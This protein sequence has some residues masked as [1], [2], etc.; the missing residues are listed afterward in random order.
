LSDLC[1]YEKV[2]QLRKYLGRR[3]DGELF[4]KLKE[5]VPRGPSSRIRPKSWTALPKF[6]K[7]LTSLKTSKIMVRM[8]GNLIALK[9]D[10]HCQNISLSTGSYLNL[11]FIPLA[12]EE[13]DISI[14][15]WILVNILEWIK[16]KYV[17]ILK[18]IVLL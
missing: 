2:I 18:Q 12:R 3:A 17:Q 9:G 13:E 16:F 7:K 5:V 10:F 1:G 14:F 8:F 6:I 4:V 15:T 11:P